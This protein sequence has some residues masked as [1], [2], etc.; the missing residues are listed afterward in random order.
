MCTLRLPSPHG[1]YNGPCVVG[2]FKRQMAG[3]L[4]ISHL[5]HSPNATVRDMDNL[6]FRV[7]ILRRYSEDICAAIRN[8][9]VA[10]CGQSARKLRKNG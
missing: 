7:D 5:R 8:V 6:N 2:D 3:I 1:G 9:H 4:N 10:I